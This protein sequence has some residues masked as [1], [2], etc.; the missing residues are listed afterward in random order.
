MSKAIKGD[1]LEH[2]FINKTHSKSDYFNFTAKFLDKTYKITSCDDVFSKN[3]LDYGSLVLCKT[4]L[5]TYP[6][7]NGEILDMCCGY[8]TIAL[9]LASNLKDCNFHL[10]DINKT[11]IE[12][13]KINAKYN[14][15]SNIVEIKESNMF[16]N[17]NGEYDYIVSNPP[18]KA[19]KKV[20]LDFADNSINFLKSGGIL[21]LVI[22]K[23]LGAD[24]LKSHLTNLYGNCEVLERDK[25]YYILKC[26]K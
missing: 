11:G 9:L 20:L 14:N 4:F 12:L 23:N 19:G 8:G 3:E 2:Y 5:K 18:I 22:K 25:G 21:M 24:S 10:A 13:S 7:A 1:V 15:I 26:V 6:N 16:E 17:I